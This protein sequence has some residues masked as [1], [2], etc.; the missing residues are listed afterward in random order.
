MSRIPKHQT[1]RTAFSL[2]EVALA[3][4]IFAFALVSLLGL[5]PVALQTARK[6]LDRAG[7]QELARQIE[8]KIVRDKVLPVGPIYFDALGKSLP[9][10]TNAYYTAECA[11]VDADFGDTEFSYLKRITVTITL[12]NDPARSHQFAYLLHLP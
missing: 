8:A 12:S 11:M 9:A 6:N 5:V 10:P 3:I 7:T 1:A 4:G 2:C